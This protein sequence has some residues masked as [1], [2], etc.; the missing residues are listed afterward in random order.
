MIIGKM[1][2]QS[3]QKMARKKR[4]ELMNRRGRKKRP[5]KENNETTREL[6]NLVATERLAKRRAE[7]KEKEMKEKKKEKKIVKCRFCG[8]VVQGREVWLEL[9]DHINN[10]HPEEATKIVAHS[11]NQPGHLGYW[12]EEENEM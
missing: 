10:E 5:R 1:D 6:I 4:E 12:L 11:G 9:S 3:A 2:P 8:L 7:K